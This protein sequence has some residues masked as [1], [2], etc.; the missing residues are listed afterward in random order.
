MASKTTATTQTHGLVSKDG[1]KDKNSGMTT[2][3]DI[4][5]QY[6][7]SDGKGMSTGAYI[8]TMPFYPGLNVSS[9]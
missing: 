9:V 7:K 3:D 2:W 8:A 6:Q 4:M 5:K 1:A